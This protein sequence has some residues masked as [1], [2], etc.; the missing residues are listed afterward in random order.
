MVALN[1]AAAVRLWLEL[2][3]TVLSTKSMSFADSTSSE[4]PLDRL[5]PETGNRRLANGARS[6]NRSLPSN[7]YSS[8]CLRRQSSPRLSVQSARNADADWM[9]VCAPTLT[10]SLLAAGHVLVGSESV[11]ETHVMAFRVCVP[12]QLPCM[13]CPEVQVAEQGRHPGIESSRPAFFWNVS[14]A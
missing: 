11:H 2:M 9:Y 7:G 3:S 10:G 14:S 5:L 8:D 6:S 1:C 4:G 12:S 13:Y